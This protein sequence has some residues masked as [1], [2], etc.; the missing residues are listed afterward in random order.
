MRGVACSCGRSAAVDVSVVASIS[1]SS[2]TDTSGRSESTKPL[3]VVL[4]DLQVCSCNVVA[5]QS[6]VQ[7]THVPGKR[8]HQHVRDHRGS[9]MRCYLQLL[10][11]DMQVASRS[12]QRVTMRGGSVAK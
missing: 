9:V 12:E 2:S 5:G 4:L 11:P 8:K 1:G 7:L 6:I 3:L 10:K